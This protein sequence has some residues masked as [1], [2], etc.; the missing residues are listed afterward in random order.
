MGRILLSFGVFFLVI[1]IGKIRNTPVSHREY[2][3]FLAALV[4]ALLVFVVGLAL[5]G[6]W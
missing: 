5:L 3:V 4:T 6:Q 1:F 2:V